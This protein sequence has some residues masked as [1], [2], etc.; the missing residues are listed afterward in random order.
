MPKRNYVAK[1]II[2]K[3]VHVPTKGAK[4][5][6]LWRLQLRTGCQPLL[7]KTNSSAASS[8]HYSCSQ[9]RLSPPLL[10]P[11]K[12][13]QQRTLLQSLLLKFSQMYENTDLLHQFTYMC[14]SLGCK[15]SKRRL[16]ILQAELLWSFTIITIVLITWPAIRLSAKSQ[17]SMKA[18]KGGN[19]R[20]RQYVSQPL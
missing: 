20:E 6:G 11:C 13:L 10:Q 8:W 4:A 12:W 7:F 18:S 17:H 5:L 19:E 15:L 9:V 2:K 16:K 1:A 14:S 3:L